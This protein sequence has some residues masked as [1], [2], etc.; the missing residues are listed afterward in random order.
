MIV[1]ENDKE[2]TKALEKYL[3]KNF[4]MKGLGPLKYFM[5]I[6]VSRCNK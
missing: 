6:E 2:E 4:E 5:G 3:S 1:T